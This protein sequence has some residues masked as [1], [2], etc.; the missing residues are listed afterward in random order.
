MREYQVQGLNWMVGLHYNGIN[1]I[2][3]DEMVRAHRY[4]SASLADL[5]LRQG[6]G[7]TL[8]TI[9]F[10]GYLKFNRGVTGPHLVIV[11]KSTLDNWAREFARWV[12]GFDV[13]LLKGGKEERVRTTSSVSPV[14]R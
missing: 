3:A 5:L 10:L 13:V 1:G 11:P 7:K 8:Q 12:P 2:L 4:S 9:S 6:L 14:P